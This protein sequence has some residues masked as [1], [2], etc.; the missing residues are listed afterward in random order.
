MHI[1]KSRSTLMRFPDFMRPVI[2]QYFTTVPETTSRALNHLA[3]LFQEGQ[4]MIDE[5]GKE[6]PGEKRTFLTWILDEASGEERTALAM[7]NRIL[8]I[9]FAAIHTS[10]MTFT[11]ALYELAAQPEYLPPLR[12][13]IEAVV[14]QYGWSKLALIHMNKLD[15]FFKES[16]RLN[17]NATSMDRLALKEFIFSDG[18]RI[19]KGTLV[20]AASIPT[21]RNDDVYPDAEVFDPFRFA[22]IREEEGK[23]TSNQFV[24]TS[25]DYIIFGHGK[26][27]C[28]GRFF[29]VTQLK[30]IMA[31]LIL[32]YDIKLEEEGVKPPIHWHGTISMPN[33][34]GS[35]LFRRR[36]A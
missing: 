28:P 25:N 23:G 10:S 4:E 31:H 26:N 33:P 16:Q 5:Y 22:K 9:N 6:Y 30:T 27:S 3:P 8:G 34:Q 17:G 2:A 21:H 29:A 20:Y 14:E 7:A 19:P 11:H 36:R 32:T 18:T 24:A 15:S 13:E 1:I 12:E 35:I